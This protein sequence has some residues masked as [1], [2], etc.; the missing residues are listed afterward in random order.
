MKFLFS[1]LAATLLVFSACSGANEGYALKGNIQNAANLQMVLELA[2]FDRST[3]AL[4]KAAIDAN[5]DFSIPQ[6][7]AWEEGLY[8]LSIGAK[9]IYF[10]LDG[11]EKT[12]EIKADLA[13][14]E[15]MGF[16][17]NG[18]PTFKCYAD[19]IA[20]LMGSQTQMTPDRAK[21]MVAKGCTPMMRAFMALQLYGSSPASYMAELKQAGKDLSDA[22]PSSKF[23]TD[24]T[25]LIAQVEQQAAQQQASEKIKIGEM[26]PDISLPDPNG[27][28]RNLSDLKGKVVLLDFWAS[29][30]GPCRKANPHVV[31]L[32][33]K[34]K[35]RG[36]DVFSV[37]LDGADPRMKMSPEDMA[38]RKS[39]GKTKWVAAIEQDQL[40]W[41]NHVS[42][43]QHWGSA[44]A[45][46]YGVNSI[47]RTFL[48][49]RTGKIVAI[50]LRDNLEQEILKAL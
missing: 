29:W 41:A 39:E 10:M 50:N 24:Y 14:M 8:R 21:T 42:D 4:G 18:S 47:P 7:K 9:K 30:C 31:E 44:P 2:H 16:E 1:F 5:G 15:K 28:V 43:L 32:Y 13:N 48:I 22:N 17:I 37:S 33:K 3:V 35:D 20:E 36:F 11:K 25:A 23:A 46:V 12:V 49:D 27:K 45:A 34:Y 26:A 40:S 38:R 6:E 19:I